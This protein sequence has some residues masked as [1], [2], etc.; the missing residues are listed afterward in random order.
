MSLRHFIVLAATLALATVTLADTLELTGG[1]AVRGDVLRHKG[2]RLIVDIGFTVLEI[3][4]DAVIRLIEDDED[5]Q[6]TA[7]TSGDLYRLDP[8]RE[9]LT[10]K[11]NMTRCAEAVVQVRTPVGLGSGFVIQADGYVVTNQHVIS[12]EH[13]LTVTVFQSEDG[14]LSNLHFDRVRIVAMSPSLDLALLKIENTEGRQFATVPLAPDDTLR[15]GQTVFAIGSPLG[16]DRSV[17]QG[18]VSLTQRLV[19]DHLLIQTTT[20]INPGNSG[21][22]LFN[23]KG[24][25]VGVSDLKIVGV[26]LE[27]LNFA[28]PVG[29]VQQFLRNR[30]AY[31]FDPRNPNSGFRY[32]RPPRAPAATDDRED[33]P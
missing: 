5:I 32:P 27:G 3:P 12:G 17:S 1:H 18:I 6:R 4:A 33:T 16:L 14:Q 19:D 24:E 26:G 10:V 29:A 30:N 20:Q 15:Q 21:G 23:L 31:A 8:E 13:E 22:P 28:I 25:V 7:T 9:D 2:D 11:E